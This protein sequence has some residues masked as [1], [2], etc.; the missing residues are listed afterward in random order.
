[1]GVTHGCLDTVMAHP[2]LG[3]SDVDAGPHEAREHV[4]RQAWKTKWSSVMPISCLAVRIVTQ[5]MH[6]WQTS[7]DQR[8]EG[9][10]R[11]LRRLGSNVPFWSS[12]SPQEGRRCS[13]RCRPSGAREALPY[14]SREARHAYQIGKVGAAVAG[15]QA[16]E[17]ASSDVV[18]SR[19][20]PS[21]SRSHGKVG[22]LAREE[23]VISLRGTRGT[24]LEER[25][26]ARVVA[27]QGV[28]LDPTAYET[29]LQGVYCC[30]VDALPGRD[31]RAARR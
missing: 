27:V 31:C 2:P 19:I 17:L 15:E 3:G 4:C 18:T 7:T 12:W 25:V 20:L 13:P 11:C 23:R 8:P 14:A 28:G 10:E 24:P 22:K 6:R 9:C 30:R 29:L 5:G 26:Q 21:S 1:M 16:R